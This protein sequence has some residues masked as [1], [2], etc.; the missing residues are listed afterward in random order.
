MGTHLL[1]LR[2]VG[3]NG[4][5][6]VARAAFTVQTLPQLV[7]RS[8]KQNKLMAAQARFLPVTVGYV[9]RVEVFC[10]QDLLLSRGSEKETVVIT[11]E[12]LLAALKKGDRI[13][14]SRPIALVFALRAMNATEHWQ[15]VE[16]A[17]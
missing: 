16:F 3:I 5:A 14:L 15:V 1:T 11:R 2:A 9:G 10:D 7:I 8:D 4:A 17:P 13:D 6:T 12:E